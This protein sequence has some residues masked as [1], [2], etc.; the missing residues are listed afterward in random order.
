MSTANEDHVADAKELL[1]IQADGAVGNA[2]DA[3]QAPLHDAKADKATKSGPRQVYSSSVGILRCGLH[4]PGHHLHR[5]PVIPF[6][7]A[8]R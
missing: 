8:C 5:F 1:G 2:K 7:D 3:L 6:K 4:R